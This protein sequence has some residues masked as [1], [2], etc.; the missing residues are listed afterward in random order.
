MDRIMSAQEIKAAIREHKREMKACGVR[1]TS[2]FN[3]GLD[4]LTY[5]MNAR[6]FQLKTELERAS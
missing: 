4:R 2:C 5:A 6:L 3:G 1:V